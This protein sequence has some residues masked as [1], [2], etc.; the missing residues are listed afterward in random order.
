M[1]EKEGELYSNVS[2]PIVQ[3]VLNLEKDDYRDGTHIGKVKD[4]SKS[5]NNKVSN[6]LNLPP[7]SYDLLIIG[8]YG[9]VKSQTITVVQKLIPPHLKGSDQWITDKIDLIKKKHDKA[10]NC[11]CIISYFDHLGAQH[12]KFYYLEQITI[13][14]QECK[15]RNQDKGERITHV[16]HR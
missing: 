8:S 6:A 15:R 13:F 10:T 14:L 4:E 16:L 9:E 12:S 5:G 11:D 7:G 2:S 3:S 1:R